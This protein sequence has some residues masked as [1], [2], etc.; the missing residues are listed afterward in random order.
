V[1]CS[2][3]D[4]VKRR[5]APLVEASIQACTQREKHKQ[6]TL[7]SETAF[8]RMSFDQMDALRFAAAD[9]IRKF[10]FLISKGK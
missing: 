8:L 7:A 5:T 9:H 4:A 2:I 10:S 1:A 3:S 6:T